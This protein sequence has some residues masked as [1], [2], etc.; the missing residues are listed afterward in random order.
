MRAFT[1]KFILTLLFFAGFS[2][3]LFAAETDSSKVRG[4]IGFSPAFRSV[5]LDGA[6]VYFVYI[7]ASA[8]AS[9]DLDLFVPSVE[10]RAMTVGVR[11]GPEW[12]AWGGAGGGGEERMDYNLYWRMSVGGRIARFDL[13]L[14]YSWEGTTANSSSPADNLFK[15][16]AELRLKLLSNGTGLLFKVR[17]S[18]V[19]PFLG[20][21]LFLGYDAN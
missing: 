21:G 7:A 6:T 3:L 16:G 20:V 8:G 12:T 19:G 5:Q 18:R 17:G 10:S 2:P 1:Q 15:G 9:V 14:G 11:F 4:P 13:L